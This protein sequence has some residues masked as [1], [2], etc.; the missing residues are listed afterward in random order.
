MARPKKGIAD[1]LAAIDEEKL[2]EIDTRVDAD[3][4]L[5]A[6]QREEVKERAR[7]HVRKK[8]QERLTDELFAKEV[9]LAEIEFAHP[10][11][12]LIEVTID[13]PDFAYMIALDNVG[14]YH[15]LTYDVPKRKYHTIID[16]MARSWEH[17]REIHARRRK[18]DIARD[19]FG[20]G[21]NAQRNTEFSIRT[22]VTTTRSL[23]DSMGR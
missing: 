3:L 1:K 23:R 6:E 20:R 5:T 10:E 19:P 13:L 9:R 15:G 8:A 16:Q 11:D 22:G 7:K 12:E 21:I 14:Y 4:Q 18:G 17:D 2:A